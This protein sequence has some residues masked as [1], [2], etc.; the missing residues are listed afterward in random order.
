MA[1]GGGW[2]GREEGGSIFKYNI[3]RNYAK[4]IDSETWE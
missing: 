1:G 2:G 3:K 4:Y